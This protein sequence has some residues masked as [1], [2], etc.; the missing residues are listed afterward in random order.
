MSSSASPGPTPRRSTPAAIAAYRDALLRNAP[1]DELRRLAAPL[2]P[3]TVAWLDRF[4]AAQRER[5]QPDPAFVRRLD[6]VIATAPGPKTARLDSGSFAPLR[7]S[8]RHA[9]NGRVPTAAQSPARVLPW[10]DPRLAVGFLATAALLV[11]ALVAGLFAFGPLRPR[12]QTVILGAPVVPGHLEFL[13]TSKG[14]PDPLSNAYGVGVDAQGNVWVADAKDRF[15]IFAPDGTYLDTWGVSGSREGEFEFSSTNAPVAR[16]YGD[17]AFDASGNIYVADTGNSR[18]QKFAPD[19]TFL[20]AWGSEG[21]EDGQFLSPSGIAVGPDGNVYVSDEGRS[22]VQKFASDGRFLG[23]VAERDTSER[24]YL[25]PAGVAV[26]DHGDVWIAD[27]SNQR[28]QRFSGAGDFLDAWG[29][30]GSDDGEFNNPNDVAVDA[31]GRVY[32]ADDFN[33]RVQVLDEQG[34]FLAKAGG[35]GGE[36]GQL[37]DPLGVAANGNGIVYVSDRDSIQAFRFVPD[38]VATPSPAS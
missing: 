14:G 32:V 19:R 20:L 16:G 1:A 37:N 26:D 11:L 13:W 17:V 10:L 27:Y 3:Q 35:Y 12:P 7:L 25:N 28:I 5:I 36:P 15:Q 30:S 6:R 24:R 31:S 38:A 8:R 34:R 4:R 33:N 21:K 29:S 9:A 18:V 23:I 2:D 22:D